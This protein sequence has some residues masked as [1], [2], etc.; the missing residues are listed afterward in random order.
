MNPLHW[1]R[2]HQLAWAVI[3]VLGAVLGA[4]LGFIHSPFFLCS[5]S[6]YRIPNPIGFGPHSAFSL[7]G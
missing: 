5:W 3:S 6:G 2:Q 4:L 1:T 7:P